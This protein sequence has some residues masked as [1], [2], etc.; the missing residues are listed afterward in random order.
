VPL[1][2]KILHSVQNDMGKGLATT[3][4]ASYYNMISPHRRIHRGIG[5]LQSPCSL[6]KGMLKRDNFCTLEVVLSVLLNHL[7]DLIDAA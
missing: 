2:N 7:P 5:V 1:L 4:I 6:V 3:T